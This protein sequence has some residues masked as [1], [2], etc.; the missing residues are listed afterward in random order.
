MAFSEL[1]NEVRTELVQRYLDK[2]R[3]KM[4][5][6]SQMLGYSA[7]SWNSSISEGIFNSFLQFHQRGIKRST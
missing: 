5:A 3:H 6:I 2:P 4:V 7:P 1:V